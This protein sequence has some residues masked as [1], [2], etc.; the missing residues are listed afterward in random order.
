LAGATPAQT[1]KLQCGICRWQQERLYFSG[2]SFAAHRRLRDID[3]S[4]RE[5]GEFWISMTML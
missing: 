3:L 1:A 4:R 5:R 2:K